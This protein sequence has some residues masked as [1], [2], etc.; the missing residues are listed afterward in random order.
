MKEKC[1]I[2]NDLDR[3]FNLCEIHLKAYKNLKGSY[4]GWAK[5]LNNELSMNEYLEK[6]LN[7]QDTGRA[8]RE[9]AKYLLENNSSL[10]QNE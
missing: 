6:I 1:T 10:T 2:C 4:E 5:A 3:E 9:V 8:I 7:L